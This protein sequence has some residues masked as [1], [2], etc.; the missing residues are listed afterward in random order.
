MVR[1]MVGFGL[2][3]GLGLCLKAQW[4]MREGGEGVVGSWQL[5][6]DRPTGQ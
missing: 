5:V 6:L 3:L 2:G 1:V 4:C